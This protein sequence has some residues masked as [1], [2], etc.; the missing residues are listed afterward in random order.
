MTKIKTE[1]AAKAAVVVVGNKRV[2][3][4][5]MIVREVA[6]AAGEVMMMAVDGEVEVVTEMVVDGEVTEVEEVGEEAAEAE[7]EAAAEA[8]EEAIRKEVASDSRKNQTSLQEN[9]CLCW[10]TT[11]SSRRKRAG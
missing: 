11:S 5:G 10:S 8:E 1:G 9:P 4:E 2:E 6:A 7:I 3:V